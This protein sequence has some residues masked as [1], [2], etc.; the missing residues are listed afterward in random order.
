MTSP[1]L[2][3]IMP[4]HN[5]E[6]HLREALDSIVIQATHDLEVIALEHGSTDSTPQILKEYAS[7]LPLKVIT[8]SSLNDWISKTN[9]GMSMANGRYLSFLHHD[10]LWLPSRLD[11]LRRLSQNFPDVVLF[12][13]PSYYISESGE[14]VGLLHCPLPKRVRPIPPDLVVG[15]LL[16][17][18][19]ISTPAPF[20]KREMAL[21]IGPMDER[22][23][24]SADWK[25]WIQLSMQGTILY[26]PE[27]LTSYRI[28]SN[29]MTVYRSGGL[30][31]FR[32]Q[33]DTVLEQYLPIYEQQPYSRQNI[34]H[35]A[36]F[37]KEANVALAG[38]AR[39]QSVDLWGLTIRFLRLGPI[40]WYNF[41]RF[42]R[43]F[44]R[45]LS[46]LRIGLLSRVR[47]KSLSDTS[48]N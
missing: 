31:E 16:V 3:V 43:I 11:R 19:F 32:K 40:G 4:V 37:S 21:K 20:F 41:F 7:I 2:S 42:S 47:K 28:H 38:F 39:H 45:V 14:R 8:N 27:P 1:L 30:I 46:R 34:L 24:Y 17:Q 5:G 26:W 25:Y 15:R 9:Y 36:E 12:V 18:N 48:E 33:L 35:V 22:L 44:E 6:N 23:W 29:A 10:D 13:N